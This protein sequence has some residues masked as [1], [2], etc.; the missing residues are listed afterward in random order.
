MTNNNAQTNQESEQ[1][2]KSNNQARRKKRALSVDFKTLKT[3]GYNVLPSAYSR[4]SPAFNCGFYAIMV[5]Q[6][7]L[8]NEELFKSFK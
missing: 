4:L 8:N 3:K 6:K 7:G 2:Y 5:K 1:S